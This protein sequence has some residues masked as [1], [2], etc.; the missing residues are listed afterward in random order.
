MRLSE[1]EI[2][3]ITTTASEVFGADAEVRLFGSRTDDD[4]RGGD[5]DLYITVSERDAE[6]LVRA[7]LSFLARLKRCIGDQKIDLLIDYPGRKHRPAVLDVARQTAVP[8][9]A[10]S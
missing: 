2:A 1:R 10:V 5:I 3:A 9:R 4:K 7:E 8:L 6:R